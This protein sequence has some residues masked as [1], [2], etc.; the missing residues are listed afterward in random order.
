[1]DLKGHAL[2]PSMK[3]ATDDVVFFY[4]KKLGLFKVNRIRR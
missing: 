1:V 4:F 2:P 3:F